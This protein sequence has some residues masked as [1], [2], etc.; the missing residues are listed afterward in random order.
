MFCLRIN[1]TLTKM[2]SLNVVLINLL[3]YYDIFDS[4]LILICYTIIKW[5]CGRN[6]IL[7]MFYLIF[8]PLHMNFIY[9]FEFNK[10]EWKIKFLNYRN[11]IYEYLRISIEMLC[12]IWRIQAIRTDLY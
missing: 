2:M 8:Y 4:R 6:G 3:I 7:A 5:E 12:Y 1:L 10:I 9:N 11:Y